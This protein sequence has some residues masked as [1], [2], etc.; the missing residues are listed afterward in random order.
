MPQCYWTLLFA[1]M[2]LVK[3]ATTCPVSDLGMQVL[4]CFAQS[5]KP[6]LSAKEEGRRVK[7]GQLLLRIPGPKV[8]QITS[9]Q[10]LVLCLPHLHARGLGNIVSGCET[11]SQ[12]QLHA[13][14]EGVRVSRRSS[15]TW[16]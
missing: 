2:F 15:A 14:E 3:W 16:L 1:L 6:L 4:L 5:V 8:T 13:L 10:E 11:T 9:T 7:L 12:K